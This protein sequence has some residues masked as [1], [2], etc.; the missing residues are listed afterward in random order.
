MV[1]RQRLGFHDGLRARIAAKECDPGIMYLKPR[2]LK[3]GPYGLLPGERGFLF[4]RVHQ[5]G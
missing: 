4:S 1:K 5:V 2:Y 3:T